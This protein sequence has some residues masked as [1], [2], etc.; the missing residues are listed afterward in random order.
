M[1]KLNFPLK[2]KE[3]YQYFSIAVLTIPF[4]SWVIE[5]RLILGLYIARQAMSITPIKGDAIIISISPSKQLIITPYINIIASV[6]LT[7][8]KVGFLGKPVVIAFINRY[9]NTKDAYTVSKTWAESG[10][11]GWKGV[12]NY[13]LPSRVVVKKGIVLK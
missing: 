2:I 4:A 3:P 13:P 1:L 12:I 11:I 7:E 6:S 8:C 9:L 5:P 10:V